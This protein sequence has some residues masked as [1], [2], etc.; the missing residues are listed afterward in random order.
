MVD[1]ANTFAADAYT[2]WDLGARYRLGGE[3][4]PVT[5]RLTIENVT[6]KTYVSNTTWS[7]WDIGAPR[8][9]KLSAEFSL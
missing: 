5:L 7:A 4:N 8:T 3:Q 1:D 9:I 2:R 6:D